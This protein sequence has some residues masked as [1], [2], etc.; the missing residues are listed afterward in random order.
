ML[1]FSVWMCDSVINLCTLFVCVSGFSVFAGPTLYYWRPIN[2]SELLPFKSPF[3]PQITEFIS[4]ATRV[5][6]TDEGVVYLLAFCTVKSRH[7]T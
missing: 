1:T 5:S 3:H 2:E 7:V 6:I 4:S